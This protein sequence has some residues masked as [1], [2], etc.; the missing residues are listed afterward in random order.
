MAD[1]FVNAK[2]N[3]DYIP[4]EKIIVHVDEFLKLMGVLTDDRR[5]EEICCTFAESEKKEGISMC[6]VLDA[7]EKRGIEKGMEWGLQTL[8]GLVRDGLL[9]IEEAA[10]RSNMTIEEFEKL[11]NSKE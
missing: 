11:L 6:K 4:D 5:Y 10:K 9:S 3:A 2:Q 1:Y 7:R 8:A